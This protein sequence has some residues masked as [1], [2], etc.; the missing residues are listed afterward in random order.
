MHALE[1]PISVGKA[2]EHDLQH[3]PFA[4]RPPWFRW[5]CESNNDTSSNNLPV[6]FTAYSNVNLHKNRKTTWDV[7]KKNLNHR[8]N[9]LSTGAGFLSSTVSRLQTLGRLSEASKTNNLR[10]LD[11]V[12][13]WLFETHTF[14]ISIQVTYEQKK[15][16]CNLI[17]LDC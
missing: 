15:C 14:P 1:S 17:V 13:T 3:D 7:F 8:I 5:P 9:Y 10:H 12:C 4:T 2:L 11:P 16:R 6:D